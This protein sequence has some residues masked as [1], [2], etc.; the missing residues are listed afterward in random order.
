MTQI[1]ITFTHAKF[2]A[3]KPTSN[4]E[5]KKNTI[6]P[7]VTK[8]MKQ[9]LTEN[10]FCAIFFFITV[11]KIKAIPGS[12]NEDSEKSFTYPKT[13]T[14]WT[15]NKQKKILTQTSTNLTW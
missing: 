4:G 3:S 1:I 5:K 12:A 8:P 13:Y 15:G 7:A 10:R 14:V 6:F 2:T 9:K 11:I